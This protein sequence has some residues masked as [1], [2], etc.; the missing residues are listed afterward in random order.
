VRRG[1]V[2]AIE[3][4]GIEQAMSETSLPAMA[5]ARRS[6]ASDAKL[7]PFPPTP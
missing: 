2:Q 7:I 3:A 4:M 6:A 1:P 5:R